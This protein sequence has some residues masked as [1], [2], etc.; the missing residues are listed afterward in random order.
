MKTSSRVLEPLTLAAW[1]HGSQAKQSVLAT[2]VRLI[3]TSLSS[4]GDAMILG[5]LA[6]LGIAVGEEIDFFGQAPFGEPILICVRDTVIALRR[7]EAALIGVDEI[8]I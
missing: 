4:E 6:D 1:V 3:V 2:S 5:R 8:L 7:D